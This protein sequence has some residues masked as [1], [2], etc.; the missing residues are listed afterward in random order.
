AGIAYE[1]PAFGELLAEALHERLGWDAEP[2]GLDAWWELVAE[3]PLE[4]LWMAA[5]SPTRAVK[6][7]F[8]HI[9][10][11][12]LENFR[13]SPASTPPSWEFVEGILDVQAQ[14]LQALR[15]TERARDDARRRA[16]DGRDKVEELREEARRLRR[17][18]GELR[19][20]RAAAGRRA[21]APGEA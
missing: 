14:T 1:S 7:E 18:N 17:E 20:A 16:D 9:A 5:L 10:Q 13:E 2:A 15:E 4:A 3:R 21:V 19:A 11:H 12:A 6:K 8:A